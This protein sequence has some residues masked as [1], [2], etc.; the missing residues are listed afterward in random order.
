MSNKYP[1]KKSSLLIAEPFLGDPNFERSVVL[2]CEH[3]ESGSF[4]F[5]INQEAE[6]SLTEVL[7]EEDLHQNLPVFCGGPVEQNTLHFI[8]RRPHLIHNGIE[9]QPGLFW[10]GDFEEVSSLINLGKVTKSDI[11]FFVGYSG[12]GNGQLDQELEQKVWI[13]YQVATDFI[14]E[15]D[16]SQFWRQVLKK[17]GGRH[18]ALANYPV[19]PR[20]N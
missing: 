8:H 9:I 6:L 18:K 10:G 1:V 11:R 20:L 12:W 14:F 17:M 13:T 16:P 5:V 15:T 19:D 4:G 3:N 7:E 2:I